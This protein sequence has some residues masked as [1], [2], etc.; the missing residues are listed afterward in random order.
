MQRQGIVRA[1]RCVAAVL[2][3]MAVLGC[4]RRENGPTL[5][6]AGSTSVQPFVEKLADE[7]MAA[8]PDILINVQGGGSTAGVQSI[9]EGIADIGMCSRSLKKD[10]QDLTAT[11][12]ARDGLAVIV[13]P[14]NSVESL[15]VEQVRDLFAGQVRS[16]REAGGP[17]K[18]VRLITREEGSG[19]RAAFQ[20]LIM[21]EVE[22]SDAA[23]VGDSNGA[24]RE[25]VVGDPN[26]VGYISLG[27]VDNRVKAVKVDGVS[28]SEENI[29]G[30]QYKLV[31]PFLFLTKGAARDLAGQ[32][33]Q[34]VLSREGQEH[35]V[36]EG[37]VSVRQRAV[38]P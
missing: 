31:R 14:S 32:F 25:V 13:H 11:V 7:F 12:I 37:L 38:V 24:V 4:G 23:L 20:E 28:P 15:T 9:R 29:L 8:H 3:V 17:D 21:K 30:G 34:Y 6:L 22:I 10:E 33:M 5:T 1:A 19:T 27:L 16:W 18:V 36:R 2:L 26:I 35:L